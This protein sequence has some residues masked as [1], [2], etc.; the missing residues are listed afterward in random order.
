[1]IRYDV[2]KDPSATVENPRF[3]Q[4]MTLGLLSLVLDLLGLGVGLLLAPQKPHHFH[5]PFIQVWSIQRAEYNTW[6]DQFSIKNLMFS[7]NFSKALKGNGSKGPKMRLKNQSKQRKLSINF[8]PF[9]LVIFSHRFGCN[10]W[11]PH[12][13]PPPPHRTSVY[14][15][16]HTR[17]RKAIKEVAWFGH[18]FFGSWVAS[19]FPPIKKS[20]LPETNKHAPGRKPSQ[21]E[22]IVLQPSIFRCY[23]RFRESMP[24]NQ[25]W[26]LLT[27]KIWNQEMI[28][29]VLVISWLNRWCFGKK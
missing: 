3:Q 4:L 27:P 24:K 12:F 6:L 10:V 20:T 11:I 28:A 29:G 2:I 13:L 26:M 8:P 9:S 25:K 15:N 14:I 22:R 5:W 1:M 7:V 16:T 17:S 23:L 19:S 21:K 18:W